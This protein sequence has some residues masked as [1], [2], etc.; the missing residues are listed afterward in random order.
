VTFVIATIVATLV[1][2]NALGASP[3]SAGWTGYVPI[4]SCGKTFW[5]AAFYI[6]PVIG[7]LVGASAT[8]VFARAAQPAQRAN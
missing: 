6:G 7:L 8:L 2:G 1:L 3:C 4:G 5:S